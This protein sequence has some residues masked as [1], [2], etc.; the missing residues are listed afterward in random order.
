[1]IYQNSPDSAAKLYKA[2]EDS[3]PDSLKLDIYR[4]FGWD[5]YAFLE[6]TVKVGTRDAK[7]WETYLYYKIV[8]SKMPKK[9][10]K[11][12]I[13]RHIKK[14]E[15]IPRVLNFVGEIYENYGMLKEAKEFYLKSAK[16]GYKTAYKNLAIIYA[17]LGMCDSS[18]EALKNFSL[19]EIDDNYERRRAFL[20][21][22]ICFEKNRNYQQALEYYQKAYEIQKDT[23][24]GFKI[25]YLL[26]RRDGDEALTF[27]A[28]MYDDIGFSRPNV[29]WGYALIMS[30]SLDKVKEG[31]RELGELLAIGGDDPQVRNILTH[32]FLR[33]GDTIMALK[34][35]RRA[36]ELK[37][38]DDDYRLAYLLLLSGVEENPRKFGYYLREK[39]KK[40]PVGKLVFA[41]YYRKSG[42]KRMA[43]KYYSEL[44]D[45]DLKNISLLLEAY[46]YFKGLKD[47]ENAKKTL[48][49]LTLYYPDSLGYWF[50]LGDIYLR[51][52]QPDS[53]YAMYY[54][55]VQRMGFKL[56]D[57]N[58]A[59]V[60]N[61]WAY[62]MALLNY[63]LDTAKV[64]IDR[65]YKLC[66]NEYILDSRGWIY[67][68]LGNVEEGKNMVK[69][70][71]ETYM[72][73]NRIDPEVLLHLSII[74][75][76]SGDGN[77]KEILRD[78][79]KYIDKDYRDFYKN[80][81]KMCK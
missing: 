25:A 28:G 17:K 38:D 31:I 42:N 23:L 60:L 66:K 54:N 77:A 70:A 7:V 47:L 73:S 59:S 52:K 45:I 53:I 24:L 56:S 5:V 15:T 69:E 62:T 74:S 18:L 67:F 78:V 71:A 26:A 50:E 72:K 27:L 29:Y 9:N 37:T 55:I 34:H 36:F 51:L 12:F 4:R 2:Y 75:C 30:K 16:M 46:Y 80:F 49:N 1:M 64:L 44:V 79:W 21:M 11:G 58:L 61:N 32:A 13:K 35:A 57:C 81:T 76:V 19:E 10:L 40:D 43:V 65:A 3:L 14:F 20:A 8:S 68:L 63:K 41:R 33:L 48:K 22:G 6:N 39:D